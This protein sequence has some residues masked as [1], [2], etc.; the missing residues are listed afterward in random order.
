MIQAALGIID[1]MRIEVYNDPNYKKDPKK[2]IFVQLNPDKYTVKHNVVFC[3][4]QPMGATSNELK[5]DRIES[6]EV[7]FDF[8]FDS[9][10]VVPPGKVK[11]G[12]GKMSLLDNVS[13]FADGLKPVLVNPFD[14]VKSVEEAIEEFKNLLMGFDGQKH[15]TAYL[16]LLWGGYELPCRLKNME[17]EY[18]LFRGDGCPIRAKAKCL[19]K[20][21]ATYKSMVEEQKKS[22]PDLTHERE[23]MMNDKITLLSEGI[24]ENPDHYIDV[25][26][27]NKLLSFRKINIGTKLIF[28]PIK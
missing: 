16:K 28:P 25:A 7:T 13:S 18:Y 1:K 27:R 11:D 10:G 17:V 21:T 8:I 6:P 12:K 2:T 24:Y 26:K 9:S 4:G 22:S 19:F 14:E 3:E 20:G 15:Q 5:F 23:F